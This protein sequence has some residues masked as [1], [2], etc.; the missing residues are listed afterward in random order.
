M[1]KDQ[2]KWVKIEVTTVNYEHTHLGVV[3]EEK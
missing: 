3:R 2:E 1:I